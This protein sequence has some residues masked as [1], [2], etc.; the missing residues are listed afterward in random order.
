MNL[1]WHLGDTF[2]MRALYVFIHNIF[3]IHVFFFIYISPLYG[4]LQ[5]IHTPFTHMVDG[6]HLFCHHSLLPHMLAILFSYEYLVCYYRWV[7]APYLQ[8]RGIVLHTFFTWVCVIWIGCLYIK[9][10]YNHFL[11]LFILFFIF[12]IICIFVY[13]VIFYIFGEYLLW[14]IFFFLSTRWRSAVF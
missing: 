7:I 6:V 4:L 8:R 2:D 14:K 13:S 5:Y 3:P 12:L 10:E 9:Y 11:G 1:L